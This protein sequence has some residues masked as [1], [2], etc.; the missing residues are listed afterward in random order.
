MTLSPKFVGPAIGLLTGLV[1]STSMTFIGLAVNYGFHPDFVARWLQ[2]AGLSYIVAVPLL[3]IVVPP[4]QRF[5][6]RQAGLPTP[7]GYAPP[8]SL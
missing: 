2:S 3:M 5:V 7:L 1:T 8:V 6:F 4:I